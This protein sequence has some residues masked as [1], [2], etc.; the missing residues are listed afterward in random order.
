MLHAETATQKNLLFEHLLRA[1]KQAIFDSMTPLEV[2]ARTSII[3]QGDTDAKTFYV[4]ASGSCEVL[5]Q[6][7]D[8][9]GEARQVLI[10]EPGRY[11]LFFMHKQTQQLW[12]TSAVLQDP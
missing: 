9:G 10:Y 12:A 2:A 11:L 8:S 3:K 5:L 1:T 6:T 4:L 7:P